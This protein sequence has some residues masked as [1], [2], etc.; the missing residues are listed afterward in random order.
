MEC[1]INSDLVTD[2]SSVTSIL[3]SSS[4]KNSPSPGASTWDVELLAQT[5]ARDRYSMRCWRPNSTL[6]DTSQCHIWYRHNH[7]TTIYFGLSQLTTI[8]CPVC[9][10]NPN[11]SIIQISHLSFVQFLSFKLG[12][13]TEPSRFWRKFHKFTKCKIKSSQKWYATKLASIVSINRICMIETL[14]TSAFQQAWPVFWLQQCSCVVYHSIS[15]SDQAWQDCQ[16]ALQCSASDTT[17]DM[18]TEPIKHIVG[19]C[20][21]TGI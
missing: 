11:Q 18:E 19:R 5:A 12:S 14:A 3:S 20:W 4:C 13:N 17:L 1:E 7:L 21:F 8:R 16:T 2:Q 9:T 10:E 15:T 6:T